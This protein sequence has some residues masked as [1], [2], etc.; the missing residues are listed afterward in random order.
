LRVQY[1]PAATGAASAFHEI[2]GLEILL[3]LPTSLMRRQWVTEQVDVLAPVLE[4]VESEPGRW[5][6]AGFSGGASAWR[7]R[8]VDLA[9]HTAFLRLEDATLILQPAGEDALTLRHGSLELRNEDGVHRVRVSAAVHDGRQPLNL[10]V[11]LEGD[12][13]GAFNAVLHAELR[14]DEALALA[15][16]LHTDP[17]LESL[18]GRARVWAFADHNG[19][20][21]VRGD[22]SG[23]ALRLRGAGGEANPAL[24]QGAATFHA[25]RGALAERWQVW[26]QAPRFRLGEAFWRADELFLDLDLGWER[27]VFELQAPRL[28][29]ALTS[30]LL[31]ALDRL[32]AAGAEALRDLAPRGRLRNLR[33]QADL[34][35]PEAFRLRGNLDDVSVQAWKGA[36]AVSGASGY[37]EAGARGGFV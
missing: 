19:V 31:L 25:R 12:P 6:L 13:R 11:D 30:G 17:G 8:L 26:L 28:D 3:D 20:R 22:V 4:L 10:M 35:N 7:D 21:E 18:D 32:P 24:R 5:T 34:A 23:L 33:L 2:D 29:L 14:L 27:P 9:L 37:V 36:P 1:P 16:A 15:P